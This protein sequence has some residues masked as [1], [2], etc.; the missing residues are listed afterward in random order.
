[1]PIADMNDRQIEGAETPIGHHLDQS[2]FSH[3]AGVD[4]RWKVPDSAA[5]RQ[6]D[7]QTRKVV[8]REVRLKNQRFFV[9]PKL[10]HEGPAIFGLPV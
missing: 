6:G 1:M 3:E 7:C 2:T 9:I 8:H 5:C 4:N 10:V